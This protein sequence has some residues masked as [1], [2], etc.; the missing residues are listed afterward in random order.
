MTDKPD[1]RQ[2]KFSKQIEAKETRKV[3]ARGQKDRSL[4]F[5][6]GVM[7][8]VGWS[9][10][11]PTL[12]GAIFG[13]WLDARY[14]DTV[15]WTLTFLFVGLIMGCLNAYHWVRRENARIHRRH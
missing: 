14:A 2:D 12:L 5:G 1:D 3:R 8:T 11:V 15:S 7:G 4:W 6:L 13:R 9:V 10:T